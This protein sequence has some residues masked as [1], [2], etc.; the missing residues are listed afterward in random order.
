FMSFSLSILFDGFFSAYLFIFSQFFFY[1]S[2][3]QL[4]IR[5]INF[6]CPSSVRCSFI[7]NF[8]PTL[9]PANKEKQNTSAPS[10][11]KFPDV[12]CFCFPYIVS[13]RQFCSPSPL[14]T[15]AVSASRASCSSSPS[16]IS[17]ISSPL[18]TQAPST[19]STLFALAVVSRN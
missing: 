13:V 14:S 18:L 9:L 15:A 16:Q 4:S 10:F 1:T 12:S 6:P 19:L 5:F 17:V 2:F 7:K 8:L 3:L 11:R